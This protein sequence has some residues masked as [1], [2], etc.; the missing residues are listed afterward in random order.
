MRNYETSGP[1]DQFPCASAFA[2]KTHDLELGGNCDT[3]TQNIHHL[4]WPGQIVRSDCLK[5]ANST[6]LPELPRLKL[7]SGTPVKHVEKKPDKS[8][9]EFINDHVVQITYPDSSV[10]KFSYDS[11]GT[12]IK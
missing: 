1:L 12:P 4:D 8:I 6:L 5:I 10:R 9:L 7:D 11:N 2:S 3:A